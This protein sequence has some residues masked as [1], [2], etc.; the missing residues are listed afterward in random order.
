VE[1]L[2]AYQ[3]YLHGEAVAI[4]MVQAARISRALGCCGAEECARIEALLAK[5]NLPRDLP[6]FSAQE[7]AEA[8]S[9]DKK[10]RQSGLLV[11]LNKGIGAFQMERMKDM[12]ELLE[13]CGIGA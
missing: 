10:V 7:Y 12:H 2:T 11:I 5:L 4:G 6:P 1:T 8:L 3:R 13:I 9:H